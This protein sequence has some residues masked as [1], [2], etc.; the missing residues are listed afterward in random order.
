MKEEERMNQQTFGM[1]N[2][3]IKIQNEMIAMIN[4]SN[5]IIISIN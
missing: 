2:N 4:F 3:Q 5:E 1:I